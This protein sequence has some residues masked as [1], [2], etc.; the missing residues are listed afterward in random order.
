MVTYLF[1]LLMTT[2]E[3]PA[4]PEA[5]TPEPPPASSTAS[6]DDPFDLMALAGT[7]D[8]P[9]GEGGSD[10]KPVVEPPP[11][12]TPPPVA[13]KLGPAVAKEMTEI[14]LAVNKS[15]GLE[16]WPTRGVEPCVDRGGQGITAKNIGPEEARKCVASAIDKGFPGLG[17]SYVLAIPMATIGPVTVLAIGTGEANGWAAYSCDPERKCAPVKLSAPSKWG[18]RIADRQAK[19]CADPAT[20]WF[21]AD[22]RACP[23]SS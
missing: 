9:F 3:L 13:G 1:A 16:S 14:I 6:T 23:P 10:A 20:L 8:N 18:K 22:Q 21:P 12:A 7:T 19:A 5:T 2:A 15:L 11:P 17:K 4:A